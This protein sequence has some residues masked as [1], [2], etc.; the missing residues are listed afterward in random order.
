M[1]GDMAM[2]GRNA[3]WVIGGCAALALA[4]G[5]AHGTDVGDAIADAG[6]SEFS[7]RAGDA[8]RA[9]CGDLVFQN[10]NATLTAEQQD[11]LGRCGDMVNTALNVV[12]GDERFQ[13]RYGLTGDEEVYATLRQFAGEEISTQGRYAT[14]GTSNQFDAIASRLAA[15]RRGAR[16]SSIAFNFSGV[17]LISAYN[18]SGATTTTPLLIG[19]GAGDSDAEGDLGFAWFGKIDYGFGDRDG[20]D[21]EDE[22]D[23]DSYGVTVGLD[24]AFTNGL[25]LGIAAGYNEHE[26]DFERQALSALVDPVSGGSMD[27]ETWTISSF[28]DHHWDST[29]VSGIA[30]FGNSDYDMERLITVPAS[31]AGAPAQDRRIVSNTDA[32]Q[33]S[34]QL[35]IGRTFGQAA[36]TF[37]IYGGYQMANIDIDDFVETDLDGG[38]LGLAF[39]DQ[40]IDSSQALLGATVRRAMNTGVGVLV[41]YATVEWRHEFDNDS[42]V[43]GARYAL[44]VGDVNGDGFSD[45]F[46][47][48]T[49]EP[50]DDYLDVSV[51]LSGQLPNNIVLFFEYSGIVGLE[52]TTANLLT[53][54]IRG[55]F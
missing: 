3:G 49:D 53:L 29:Y 28:F 16:A 50:D 4:T 2:L 13:N 55:T 9:T 18:D 45:N 14:E 25:V 15:I 27:I 10:S 48:P 20:S 33:Y 31:S 19:G 46:A 44:A 43:V 17:D 52:D 22:Y 42:R 34:L 38:S 24:Y 21:R 23:S 8:I 39:E 6:G 32:D 30:S 26:L 54:G 36:T 40:D 51:G 12:G 41:P 37:D 7:V 1:K 11:L 47:L 35:Q 5:T